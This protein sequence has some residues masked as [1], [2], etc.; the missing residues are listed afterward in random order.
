[1]SVYIVR[2]TTTFYY[3]LTFWFTCYDPRKRLEREET[4]GRT[5]T[6]KEEQTNLHYN[7][8]VV[9]VWW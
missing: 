7:I 3:V 9:G 4:T 6:Q 8:H 5:K 1:M 2:G